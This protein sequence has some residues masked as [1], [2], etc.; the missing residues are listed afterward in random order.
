M[1]S[2]AYDGRYDFK[3]WEKIPRLANEKMHVSEKVDGSNACVVI[4][5][6]E[7]EYDIFE[8]SEQFALVTVDG[9]HYKVAAQSRTRFLFDEKNRDNFN[10]ARWVFGNAEKLVR[11]LGYGRHY[12]EWWGSGIQ[13]GYGLV[14]GDRRFSLFDTRRWGIDSEGRDSI[15]ERP[16]EETVRELGVVPE[17]YSGPVDLGKINEVLEELDT[18]GSRVVSS[19]QKAEGV[20]VNFS[21]SRVSYK[22]FI[23]D[24]GMPKSM[25]L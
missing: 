24:D 6:F 20:I 21:L 5:P 12:G 15:F 4:L 11:I 17:L 8:A 2:V 13:R 18:N 7:P 3:K 25:K 9:V 23:D 10:F 19:Y 14:N 16:E 22:A 1:Q